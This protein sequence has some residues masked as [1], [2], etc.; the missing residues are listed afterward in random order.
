M[1]LQLT[2]TD[3]GLHTWRYRY[4]LQGQSR[5]GGLAVVASALLSC[6]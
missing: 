3:G 1:D 5:C 6:S 4:W 2:D